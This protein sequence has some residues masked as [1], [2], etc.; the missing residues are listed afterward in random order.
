MF[1]R[2]QHQRK[3][4]H[5]EDV[6][7]LTNTDSGYVLAT[8]RG[9][10]SVADVVVAKMAGMAAREVAGVHEMGKTFGRLL[11]RVRA[12]ETL[13]QGV[14]VEVG[15]REAAVDLSIVI[16]FGFSIPELAQQLRDNVIS[17]VESGTGLVVKEVNIEVVDL[18]VPSDQE[19]AP[20]VS[21]V[22]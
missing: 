4:R 1:V 20:V 19:Q 5:V 17:R 11:G 6:M 8:E 22:E 7:P 13:T 16:D 10:T 3:E 18:F 14:N 21:R 15:K 12:A 9:I 2:V